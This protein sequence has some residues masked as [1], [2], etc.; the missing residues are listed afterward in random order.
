MI[1]NICESNLTNFFQQIFDVIN[2][3]VIKYFKYK[4]K[5]YKICSLKIHNTEN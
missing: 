4:L 1:T 5:S 3:N 2:I